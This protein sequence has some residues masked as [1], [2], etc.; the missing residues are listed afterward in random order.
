[1][2]NYPKMEWHKPPLVMFTA[3]VGWGSGQ[4]TVLTAHL[5]STVSGVSVGRREKCK[6]RIIWQAIYSH[7]RR[8]LRMAPW[9]PCHVVF[10]HEL[11]GLLHSKVDVLAQ[12]KYPKERSQAKTVPFLRPSLEVTSITSAILPDE[13]GHRSGRGSQGRNRD[14]YLLVKVPLWEGYTG[15]EIPLRPFRKIQSVTLSKFDNKISIF[16]KSGKLKI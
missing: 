16:L 12:S 13:A 11:V 6:A 4:G 15:W 8:L 2:I 5:C 10:L 9:G 3:S 14:S 1:M 7:A